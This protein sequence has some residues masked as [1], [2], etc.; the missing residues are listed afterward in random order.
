MKMYDYSYCFFAFITLN[1]YKNHTNLI[2]DIL[3]RIKNARRGD[4]VITISQFF[5]NLY[6]HLKMSAL[7]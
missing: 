3:D 4:H 7:Y 5:I 6:M 2:S 1:W